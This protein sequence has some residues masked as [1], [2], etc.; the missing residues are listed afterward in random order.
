MIYDS[1]NF[2]RLLFDFETCSEETIAIEQNQI[3]QAAQLG[4]QILN[5]AGQWQTYLNALA[6]FSFEQWLKER[7]PELPINLE[8]CSV[9]Q[10][11]YAS[12]I[13]AVF[14][15]KVGEFKL[16]LLAT[17]NIREEIVILPRAVVDL[18]Q[19]AAHFYVAI[20]VQE[21]QEQATITGFIS[22]DQLV[23]R[24]QYANLQPE[25]DWTY[26]ISQDWLEPD[27]DRLLLYLRCLEATAISLPAISTN[28]LI[29]LERMQEDIV[30]IISQLQS[31]EYPLWQLLSWEQGAFLLNNPDWLAWL[32]HLQTTSESANQNQASSSGQLLQ[33][34]QSLTQQVV[35]VGLWLQ[36][37]LDEFAQNLAW[38]LLPAPVLAPVSLRSARVTA[39]QSPQEEF[40]KIVAELQGAE[41]VIPSQARAAYLDF[42]LADNPLRLYAVTWPIA[43]EESVREWALLLILGVQSGCELPQGLQLQISDRENILFEQEVETDTEDTYLYASVIG[44]LSEQF[45]TTIALSNGENIKFSFLFE[46]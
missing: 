46:P 20:A 29:S 22:Y 9:M 43:T 7:A 15:L 37:E 10:P 8:N 17:G 44:E 30:S 28:Q 3:E 11:I 1:K 24:R 26:Q 31:G 41:I 32:Y 13:E 38:T 5:E 4:S 25:P 42:N 21:E 45:L 27:S 33:I 18:P 39:A 16:C 2:E 23:D 12:I 35:N 36:D 14:N 19:Y 6:M 34:L 40:E